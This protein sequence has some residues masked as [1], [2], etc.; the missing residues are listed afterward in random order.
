MYKRASYSLILFLISFLFI[1][2][3]NALEKTN[4]Y[5]FYGNTCPYCKEEIKYLKK[6]EKKYSNI[7]FNYLEVWDNDN[8]AKLLEKV[9]EFYDIKADGVP[10]TII[11]NYYFTGYINYINPVLNRTLDKCNKKA[12][13]NFIED[14]KN[15]KTVNIN[16]QRL[17]YTEKDKLAVERNN[18]LL[19]NSAYLFWI[20]LV[21]S[22]ILVVITLFI[23]KIKNIDK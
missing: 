10:I 16:S 23:R 12:C 17:S 2:N 19:G 13:D 11:G 6:I 21:V 18:I 4:L 5:I 9:R 14:I 1:S 22:I 20:I 15:N 7:K 3:V 8:N